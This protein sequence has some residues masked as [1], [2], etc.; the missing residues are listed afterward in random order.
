MCKNLLSCLEV[1]ALTQIVYPLTH[2]GQSPHPRVRVRDSRPLPMEKR[3]QILLIF[4]FT[5]EEGLR[6]VMVKGR[7]LCSR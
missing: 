5:S 4:T 7:K 3:L 6:G 2:E 1:V